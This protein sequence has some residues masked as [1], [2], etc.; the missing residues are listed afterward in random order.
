MVR[1]NKS[2]TISAWEL[3]NKAMRKAQMSSHTVNN[4]IAV[5]RQA[6]K[7][8]AALGAVKTAMNKQANA[9]YN[10]LKDNAEK[11]KREFRT[12][13]HSL[14]TL[15]EYDAYKRSKDYHEKAL[16]NY[17]KKFPYRKWK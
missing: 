7:W 3:M 9:N 8:A 14:I 11:A 16:K 15:N 6:K 12:K 1:E 4:L 2:S 17:E 5:G 13:S 10:K